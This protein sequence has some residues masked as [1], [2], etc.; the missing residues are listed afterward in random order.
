MIRKLDTQDNIKY[1]IE[2]NIFSNDFKI[3]NNYVYDKISSELINIRN[4]NPRNMKKAN[5]DYSKIVSNMPDSLHGP[6][7]FF[8]T[9]A[10]VNVKHQLNFIHETSKTNHNK[11][12]Y[13]PIRNQ[14]LQLDV[15][16]NVPPHEKVHSPRK[17]VNPFEQFYKTDQVELTNIDFLKYRIV[18]EK[19]IK[20]QKPLF[21]SENFLENP[22]ITNNEVNKVGKLF[23]KPKIKEL[24]PSKKIFSLSDELLNHGNTNPYQNEVR[25]KLLSKTGKLL[26]WN[27]KE[28]GF[29]DTTKDWKENKREKKEKTLEEKHKKFITSKG[30]VSSY[31]EKS[32]DHIKNK[33]SKKFSNKLQSIEIENNISGG[34]T[35][36]Y[37]PKI[38]PDSNKNYWDFYLKNNEFLDSVGVVSGIENFNKKLIKK[39]I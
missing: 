28:F 38:K 17:Y 22:S 35:E 1:E 9:N 33:Q 10:K 34:F 8:I 18:K 37:T 39:K 15:L 20:E 13:D 7:L 30:L 4:D 29:F 31:L 6:N 3:T 21:I 25:E 26:W 14:N 36:R 27:N 24:S 19:E 23:P 5:F 16:P 32:P 2:K 11:Y 12:D